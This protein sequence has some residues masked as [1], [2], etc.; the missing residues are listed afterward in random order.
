VPSVR[1]ATRSVGDAR[2][3]ELTFD[4]PMES[5]TRTDGQ[6][7]AIP[8]HHLVQVTLA[9]DGETLASLELGPAVSRNPVLTL[10]L[11][12]GIAGATLELEWRDNLGDSGTRSLVIDERTAAT[13]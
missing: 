10:A 4:H 13:R 5:G 7:I 8:P 11:P 9:A 2:E 6:G 3:L 1:L 12:D